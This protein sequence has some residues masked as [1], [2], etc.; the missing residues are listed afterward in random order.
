MPP[1]T[2]APLAIVAALVVFFTAMIGLRTS[3]TAA[4]VIL[5]GLAAFKLIRKKVGF[6]HF[7]PR[8]EDHAFS[9]RPLFRTFMGSR[10]YLRTWKR[11]PAAPR[12]NQPSENPPQ[13]TWLASERTGLLAGRKVQR[14]GHR[15]PCRRATDFEAVRHSPVRHAESSS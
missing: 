3:A 14:W 13:V 7:L 10:R 5:I 8:A 12:V 6:L 4:A 1:S 9:R 11:I 2:E 15:S